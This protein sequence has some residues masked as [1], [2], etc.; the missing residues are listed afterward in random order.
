MKPYIVVFTFLG[1]FLTYGAIR[2]GTNTGEVLGAADS[3]VSDG[4]AESSIA[5]QTKSS[6]Q[7]TTKIE[8]EPIAFE[9]NYQDDSDAEYGTEKILKEGVNGVR[10]TTYKITHW[11]DEEISRD[12]ISVDITRPETQ[13]VAKGTKIIWRKLEAPEEGEIK[14][15]RKLHV[16]ATKYDGNCVGCRG[17]TYSGTPV[18]QGVCAVDPKVFTMGTCIY[19]PGYG[20]CHAEDVGG[21]IKGNRIDLGYADVT[22]G[23]WRTGWVD[24]YE[25]SSAPGEPRVS[26]KTGPCDF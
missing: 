17:L 1:L 5:I 18:V 24:T 7:V 22:K 6:F 25:M 11:F 2:F 20:V 15:W 19:V 26:K 8:E 21:A 14:Y 13:L 16:W 12:V 23:S 9:T 4:V 10:K 3:T